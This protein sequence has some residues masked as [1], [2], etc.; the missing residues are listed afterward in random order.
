MSVPGQMVS[1]T[2]VVQP[3]D[4][5]QEFL[6]IEAVVSGTEKRLSSHTI[7]A[8][9]ACHPQWLRQFAQMEHGAQ[10]WLDQVVGHLPH[11]LL[12]DAPLKM[13]AEGSGLADPFNAV[14]LEVSG[15][16]LSAASLAND[17]P[18]CRRSCAVGISSLPTPIPIPSPCCASPGLCCARLWSAAPPT[19]PVE[20]IIPCG[21]RI[22]SWS[23]RWSTTITITMP[24]YPMPMISLGQ[25]VSGSFLLVDGHPVADTDEFTICLNSYR[26][27]GTGGYGC[28]V[29]CPV[30]REIPH[31]MSELLLEY[32]R[33]HGGDIPLP[34]AIT[35][36][37]KMKSPRFISRGL[38]LS[39]ASQYCAKM[40]QY[41]GS[42]PSG[43]ELLFSLSVSAI[44][45]G[46]SAR[47][48]PAAGSYRS[49]RPPAPPSA[50]GHARYG[51]RQPSRPDTLRHIFSTSRSP[52][53]SFS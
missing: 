27:S 17:G 11:P 35:E 25:S 14:Q 24:G 40:K 1:G 16:Q 45:P 7:P 44:W 46:G 41:K 39:K 6:R 13:A 51:Y 3:S 38:A 28:Y 15:A 4:R 48:P 31:E 8:G 29:G 12:P 33:R 21:S 52:C 47:R 43:R 19:S 53:C 32:F 34:P 23:P 9:G 5:G 10:D 26:A 20:R 36:S 50:S 42:Q 2:F 22:A 30:V 18:A 37:V 49:Q